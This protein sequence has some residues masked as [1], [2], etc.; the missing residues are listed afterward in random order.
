MVGDLNRVQSVLF[1]AYAI[2]RLHQG[3]GGEASPNTL[4]VSQTEAGFGDIFS[5]VIDEAN[6]VNED[7]PLYVV[8]KITNSGKPKLSIS[9]KEALIL[10]RAVT[11]RLSMQQLTNQVEGVYSDEFSPLAVACSTIED[12]RACAAEAYSGMSP[13]L[14]KLLISL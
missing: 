10:A 11:D 12:L 7:I 2:C 14:R 6:N 8:S 9:G 13:Q 4:V 1:I 5:Q 3:F